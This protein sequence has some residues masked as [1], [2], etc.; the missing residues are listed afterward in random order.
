MRGA[1]CADSGTLFVFNLSSESGTVDSATISIYLDNFGST[2]YDA[3]KVILE[4]NK[5]NNPPEPNTEE[6]M[7]TVDSAYNGKY[8]KKFPINP[9]FQHIKE[10]VFWNE[11]NDRRKVVYIRMLCDANVREHIFEGCRIKANQF[12]FGKIKTAERWRMKPETLRKDMDK[13]ENDGIISRKV[14]SKGGKNLFSIITILSFDVTHKY[15]HSII[16]EN[17]C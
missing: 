5:K 11:L 7:R 3:E 16:E 4:Q 8:Y 13:F 9:V 6:L 2:I 10:D 15:T 17:E 12:V 14:I 1:I